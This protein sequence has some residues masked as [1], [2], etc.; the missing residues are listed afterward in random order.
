MVSPCLRA[1]QKSG[2]TY[3]EDELR[4]FAVPATTTMVREEAPRMAVE[5]VRHQHPHAFMLSG[6]L[7]DVLLPD[8]AETQRPGGI[9]DG[10]VRQ[11]PVAIV[12]LQLVDDPEEEGMLRH[13]AHGVVGDA[14]WLGATHPGWVGEKRVES[15]VAPLYSLY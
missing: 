7:P 5:H 12:V 4:I 9:H 1:R 14:R 6:R 11:S 3:P 15:A 2:R 8:H 10:D 13:R